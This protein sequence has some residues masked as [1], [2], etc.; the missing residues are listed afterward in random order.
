MLE[1]V[2]GPEGTGSRARVANYGVAGKAGTSHKASTG[3][4]AASG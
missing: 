1:T 4:Y 3:G 2:T